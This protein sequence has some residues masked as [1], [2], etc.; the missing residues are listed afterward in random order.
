MQRDEIGAADQIVELD[1]LDAEVLGA[2]GREKWIVGDHLHAQPVRAVD[3]DRADIAAADHAQRLAGDL[4]AHETVLLP[5]AGLGGDVGLRDLPGERQHQGD[6]VFGGR[7]RIAERR[8]HHDD[9]FCRRRRNVDVVDADAGAAD[10]FQA[11]CLLQNFSRD[12][13]GG[14]HGKTVEIADQFGELLLVGAELRL[15]LD[16]NAAVLEDL[17]GRGR[18]RVGDQDFRGHKRFDLCCCHH[19]RKRLIQ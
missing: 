16:G 3:H 19:P 8:V 6:R 15:K 5:F 1:L 4:H 12:L 18:Q 17:H 13:G 9:A 14:A 11:L 10:H 7:D 2:L